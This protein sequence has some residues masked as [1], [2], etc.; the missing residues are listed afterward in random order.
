MKSRHR[1]EHVQLLHPEDANRLAA[2]G[3]VASMQPIHATSD[4]LMAD[5]FWGER[6]ATAYAWR[7]LKDK[8][9]ILAFGSDAPV[10][11]PNPFLGLH[12]AVTRRRTDGSP[13]KDGWYPE[14]RLTVLEALEGFTK[15]PAYAAGME[16]CIGMLRPGYFGDL[17]MLEDDP[18]HYALENLWKIRPIATLVGGAWVYRDF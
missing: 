15:G 14:Q 4:M 7:L 17:L 11:S 16:N 9:T 5:R 8:G 18:L 12:A 2:N 10:E 1:I 6:S 13:G 3:I